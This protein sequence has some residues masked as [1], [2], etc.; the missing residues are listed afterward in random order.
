MSKKTDEIKWAGEVSA[1]GFIVEN[2]LAML[3]REYGSEEAKRLG[4]DMLR[5]WT[6]NPMI[7]P[8]SIS[9]FDA[10][11][12]HQAGAARIESLF[13]AVVDRLEQAERT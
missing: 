8:D 7:K 9:P 11:L 13:R 2:V 6:N 5:Q 12:I 10:A 3:L 1:L 4:S